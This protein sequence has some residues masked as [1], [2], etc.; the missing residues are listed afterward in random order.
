MN[1]SDL[2]TTYAKAFPNARP[3]TAEEFADLLSQG[4]AT[5]VGDAQSFILG[6]ILF[7]KQWPVNNFLGR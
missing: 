6:I 3:W 7:L 5:L 4:G 2:A 1:T